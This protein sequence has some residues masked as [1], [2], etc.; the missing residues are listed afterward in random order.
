MPNR[1][2]ASRRPLSRSAQRRGGAGCAAALA[3]AVT[4]SGAPLPA[5]AAD[6][7]TVNIS[8]TTAVVFP[9]MDGGAASAGFNYRVSRSANLTIE[10]LDASETTVRTLMAGQSVAYTS[11]WQGPAAWDFRSA[12]GSPVPDGLYTLRA[13]AIAAD[14][15]TGVNSIRTG[16]DHRAAP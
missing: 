3:L 4:L 2:T 15:G 5:L 14:G 7:V 12:N 13:S 1:P 8:G 9:A 10:A 6:P 16:I 11:A